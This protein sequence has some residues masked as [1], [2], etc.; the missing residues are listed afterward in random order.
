MRVGEIRAP[1][2]IEKGSVTVRLTEL[3]PNACEAL[4]ETLRNSAQAWDPEALDDDR[5][6]LLMD[7]WDALSGD[8]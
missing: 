3:D 4:I 2:W 6:R 8:E 5:I 1:E 7:L